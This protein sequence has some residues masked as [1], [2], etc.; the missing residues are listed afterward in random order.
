M[1]QDNRRFPL[2][3]AVPRPLKRSHGRASPIPAHVRVT[4]DGFND[5]DQDYIRR[6]LGKTLAKF[7]SSIERVTVRV[8][9]VNGPRGGVDQECDVKVVV[10]GL[11]S[12]VIKRRHAVLP[13]A[14]EEALRASARAVGS[15]LRRRRMK[16]LHRRMRRA[17][18][19]SPAI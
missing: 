11:P 14:I 18:N 2:P 16:P 4:V 15:S 13:V 6:K 1:D 19:H 3:A 10:S 7:A 5:D 12:V 8:R 9:D 17:T